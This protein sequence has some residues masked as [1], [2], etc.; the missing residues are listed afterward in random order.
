MIFI[1]QI[2][3]SYNLQKKVSMSVRTWISNHPAANL[4]KS[5]NVITTQAGPINYG[6]IKFYSCEGTNRP[7]VPM[8]W[9]SYF[10]EIRAHCSVPGPSD[11]Q[12][13]A[14]LSV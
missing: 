14:L 6:F 3:L 13:R 12:P 11:A 2:V 7:G 1:S 4:Q 5:I 8:C 9:G 10:L